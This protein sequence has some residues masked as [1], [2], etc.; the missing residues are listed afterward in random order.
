MPP[1]A[2]FDQIGGQAA[3]AASFAESMLLE[4]RHHTSGKG[5]V[6]SF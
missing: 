1:Q 5:D 2:I 4:A 3:A 6:Q